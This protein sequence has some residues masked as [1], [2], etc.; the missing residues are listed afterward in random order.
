VPPTVVQERQA[1]L[2]AL[3]CIVPMLGAMIGGHVEIVLHDL[4]QPET[5]VLR[6]ANGHITGRQVGSPVLAGPGNDKALAIL[7]QTMLAA[8]PAEHVPVYPYPTETRDG[9]TLTSGSVI[10]RDALGL[11]FAALCLN[12]D[13]SGIEA[14]HASLGRLLPRPAAADSAATIEVPDMEALMREIIDAAVRRYGKPV[15]AMNKGEKIAAVEM[16]L[17]RGLFIVKGG[18]EKA[19]AALGVTRFTIYNYLETLKG[20]K[21]AAG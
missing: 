4:T 8:E 6:I 5:S 19:A 3:E 11:P 17:E 18:V 9:R 10:L 1:I 20:R 21:P 7:A 13:F 16:M 14:A 12:G 15:G 2:R